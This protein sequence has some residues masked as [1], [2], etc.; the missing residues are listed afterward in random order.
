MVSQLLLDSFLLLFEPAHDKTYIKTCA[1]SED[2]DQ[3]AHLR[4]LT[5]SLLITSAVYSFHL[6]CFVVRWRILYHISS[7]LGSSLSLVTYFIFINRVSNDSMLPVYSINPFTL[8]GRF[9]HISLDWSI[10]YI[11]VFG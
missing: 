3:P 2:S 11:R 10:S 1:T 6:I 9:Y 4:S 5:E 7:A 8:S